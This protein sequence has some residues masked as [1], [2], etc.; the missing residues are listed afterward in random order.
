[1]QIEH[2]T[3]IGL[4]SGRTAQQQ[5]HLPIRHGLFREIIVDDH[6]VHAVVA[7]IF[8]HGAAGKRREK[9]H[10]G[11]IGRGCRNDDRIVE[12]AVLLQHFGE[13]HHGRAF[14]A[15][16]HVDT[17]ELDLLVARRVERLLIENGVERDRGLPGLP[18]ADD[19]LTLAATDRNERVNG[20]QPGGHRLVHGSARDNARR[21][22]VH[23]SA[24]F[25]I[26]RPLAVDRVA[27]RVDDAAEQSLANRSVDDSARAFDGLPFLD[28][29]VLAEDHDADVVDLEVERHSA[30]AVLEFHHLAGLN[31]IEAIDASDA[32]TDGENLADLRDLGLLAEV[33]D[34][35][36]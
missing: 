27:E 34:L 9:L 23:A 31:I 10:G 19:Q 20:L 15:D 6:R 28:L 11:G 3:G 35:L 18:I 1:M 5:R 33:L 7:E 29:T 26:D 14:L 13:L 36:F 2:V 16:G 30:H 22:D 12:R 25:R 8:A 21:F 4:A 17:I 32:V 24:L